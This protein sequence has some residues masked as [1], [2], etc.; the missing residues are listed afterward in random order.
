MLGI[1]VVQGTVLPEWIDV[2]EHMNV[3]Y[4]RIHQF[5]RMYHAEMTLPHPIYSARID[6]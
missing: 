4:K 5:M 2:N 3:A 6:D 1:E